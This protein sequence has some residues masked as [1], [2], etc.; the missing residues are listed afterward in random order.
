M[1]SNTRSGRK[2]H[3]ALVGTSLLAISSCGA[4]PSKITTDPIN[5]RP[6][7][8]VS[9]LTPVSSARIDVRS[10]ENVGENRV[11][12]EERTGAVCSFNSSEFT[13]SVTTPGAIAVPLYSDRTSAV[14]YSCTYDGETVSGVLN[15]YFSGNDQSVCSYGDRVSALFKKP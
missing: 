13:V 4:M 9:G 7:E 5:A 3:L 15:C 1:S 8:L 14:T 12:L 6:T 11:W 2:S 10:F